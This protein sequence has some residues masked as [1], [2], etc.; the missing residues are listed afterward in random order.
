MTDP[1]ESDLQ[2]YAKVTAVIRKI[3]G[4]LH[5][6]R[7]HLP[8]YIQMTREL[9]VATESKTGVSGDHIEEMARKLSECLPIIEKMV[10]RAQDLEKK[11][12]TA[13]QRLN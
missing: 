9:T 11:L 10:V 13:E 6:I 12:K 7:H 3:S 1:T 2:R 5:A 8:W 4:L